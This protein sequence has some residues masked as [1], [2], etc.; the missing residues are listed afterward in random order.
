[1]S[2][3]GRTVS[4]TTVVGV[5]VVAATVSGL[6][7]GGIALADNDSGLHA[8]VA[9]QPR[10]TP[11]ATPT[12]KPTAVPAPRERGTSRHPGRQGGP[13]RFGPDRFGPDRF[14]PDRFGAE[15]FGPGGIGLAGRALHGEFVVAKPGG[16][17]RTVAIQ[18]GSVESVSSTAITVKSTDGYTHSYVVDARTRVDARREG[19]GSI[20][21]GQQVA[22]VA[23]V[24]GDTSTAVRIVDLADLGQRANLRG[25]PRGNQRHMPAPGPQSGTN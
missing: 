15:R 19:I 2:P 16:G 23:T 7:V 13:D 3:A 17:H 4:R 10:A 18:R 9:A 1:M 12:G 24:S 14:G 21:K 6:V 5:A 20:G 11:T 8:K 22:V 25:N